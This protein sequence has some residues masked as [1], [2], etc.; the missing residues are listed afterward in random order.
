MD[1][2]I[3]DSEPIHQRVN[4]AFFSSLGTPVSQEFYQNNFIGLPVEQMLIYL[5]KEYSLK[6]TVR[7][8]LKQCSDLLFQDFKQSKL[9]PAGGVEDLLEDLKKRKY[10]LAVGSSSS[11]ELIAMIIRK[12]GL[13][14]YFDHL[15]SG[16]QV[17]R[18]KPH[19]DLF[20]KIS[21]IFQTSPAECAVI[22][23]SALGLEAA[24]AAGM[25]AVGVDNPESRQDMS[26][27]AITVRGFTMPERERIL[28]ALQNW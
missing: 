24:F 20:L 12:L 13:R 27:A 7:E 4:Q 9:V 19:P 25:K 8:M 2:V 23:D 22:E 3:I 10:N 15:V 5:K 6:Q 18:G 26:R 28:S 1:G 14:D 16:Y 21:G 11:P 17:E